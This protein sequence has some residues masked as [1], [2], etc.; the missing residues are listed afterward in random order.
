MRESQNINF[1]VNSI[2]QELNG[3]PVRK[4]SIKES[5]NTNFDEVVN[6]IKSKNYPKTTEEKLINVVKKMPHGSYNNFK[7]NYK[8]YLK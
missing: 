8:K 4:Y 7:K 3:K 6:F 5:L 1:S 2:N